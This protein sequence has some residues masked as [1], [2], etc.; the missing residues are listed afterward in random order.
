MK[1]LFVT[2]WFEPEPSFKG[3]LFIRELVAR[4]HDVQVL[5]GFPNYPGGKVYRGYRIRPWLREQMEG[6]QILRVALYP[7]HNKSGIRRALNYLSFAFSASVIGSLLVRKTDV[8]YVYHPPVTVGF[9]ASVIGFFRRTPFVIDIQDLWPDS[10]AASGMMSNSAA[11]G[12]LGKLCSFVYSRARHITVLSP[13]FKQRLIDRGVPP[14]KIDVI[15]NWCDEKAMRPKRG[16]VTRLGRADRF[17]ILFAGIMGFAQ[18]I[19]SVLAAAQ[20]RSE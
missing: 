6:I 17:C 13:G 12:I 1:I 8:M 2:Q 19:D 14:D 4:G 7:S 10:V 16:P 18:D 15:H 5:T 3:L 11:L 9:A 20:I